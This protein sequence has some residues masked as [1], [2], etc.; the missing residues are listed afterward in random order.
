MNYEAPA[1]RWSAFESFIFRKGDKDTNQCIW[2]LRKPWL[3]IY[4][5]MN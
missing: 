5:P 1:T 3:V 4:E 2:K